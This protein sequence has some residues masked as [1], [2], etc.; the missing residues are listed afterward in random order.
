MLILT[1]LSNLL[2]GSALIWSLLYA[3]AVDLTVLAALS[4]I[5]SEQAS[6]TKDTEKRVS[7]LLD[8]LATHP[9][10][11]I[12]YH[13]SGMVLNIHSDASYLS[14]I[15]AKSRMIGQYF[16]ESVP[17]K[18]KPI[19]LNGA[20]FVFCWILKIVVASAAEAEL[21]A[22]FLNYKEGNLLGLTLEEMDHL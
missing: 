22:L 15:G 5:A 4:S 10:A 21:G 11:K 16:L 14:E 2:L 18:D 13:A 8:Y 3:R 1:E 6:A 9:D 12:R 17:Q 7:K 20:I 19:A